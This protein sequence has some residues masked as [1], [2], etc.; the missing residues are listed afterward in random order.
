MPRTT[1]TQG[2]RQFRRAVYEAINAWLSAR[3][4]RSEW[5]SA[6]ARRVSIAIVNASFS[7]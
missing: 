5:R 1:G 4:A 6:V 3:T 2:H 7:P